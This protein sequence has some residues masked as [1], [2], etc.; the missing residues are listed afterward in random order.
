VRWRRRGGG[1]RAR[2]PRRGRRCARVAARGRARTRSRRSH[3]TAEPARR[4]RRDPRSASRRPDRSSGP[5]S[6]VHYPRAM[7]ERGLVTTIIPV[8]NRPA[9]LREA[10]A[11]V[12]AQTY[13]PIEIVIV[14][15]GSTD[16]T[17]DVAQEL[18]SAQP[19]ILRVIRQENA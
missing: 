18:A 10:V 12:L 6:S 2:F 13:R 16:E 5:S 15:D 19:G 4:S 7:P 11:S 3:M 8:F 9:L 1:W 17:P 14:D